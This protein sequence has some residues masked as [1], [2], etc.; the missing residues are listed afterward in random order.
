MCTMATEEM[1]PSGSAS[2]D[3]VGTERYVGLADRASNCYR[4]VFESTTWL[5]TR[6]LALIQV[7]LA[8]S[9]WG[10]TVGDKPISCSA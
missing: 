8:G 5:R 1:A 3:P 2:V 7:M 4:R 6:E 9:Q 10:P